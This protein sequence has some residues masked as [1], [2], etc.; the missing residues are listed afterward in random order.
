MSHA[1][2]SEI[3]TDDVLQVDQLFKQLSEEAIDLRIVEKFFSEIEHRMLQL[4][5]SMFDI[6]PIKNTLQQLKAFTSETP[7][8]EVWQ[9]ESNI[10]Q[11]FQNWLNLLEK[12]DQKIETYHFR[13]FCDTSKESLDTVVF[14]ALARFYRNL[15]HSPSNQSKF[16]LVITRLFTK[17]RSKTF[18][19]MSLERTNLTDHLAHLFNRWDNKT[20]DFNQVSDETMVA[21]S[22]IDEFICETQSLTSFEDLVKNNLFDRFRFFKRDL[23]EQ[24]FEPVIVAAAIECNLA[25][26]NVFNKLLGNANE[27][28]STKLTSAFDFAEAF[29]DTSPNAQVHTSEL[30]HEVKLHETSDGT[31]ENEELLHIWELLE[32]VGAENNLPPLAIGEVETADSKTSNKSLPPQDRIAPLLATLSTPQPDLKLLRDYTQKS[33]SLS[34]LD[35]KDFLHSSEKNTDEICRDALRLILW[36]EEIRENELTNPKSLPL[37]IRDEVKTILRRSQNLAEQ[38]GLLIENADQATQNRLLIVANKLLETSLKLERAIVRFSNRNLGRTKTPEKESPVTRP[39]PIFVLNPPKTAKPPVN[40]W[41]IAATILV[42]LLSGGIFFFSDQMNSAIPP[43]KNVEQIDV[44]K[45]S[46]GE[47]LQ[48]AYRKENVLFVTAKDSWSQLSKAEQGETLKN[49]LGYPSQPR[50]ET[51]IITDG[52]GAPL[53]DISA[54]GLNIGENPQIAEIQGNK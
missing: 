24:F 16:D 47:H 50:L 6:G 19:Q 29:H 11:E 43:P 14:S 26:G 46:K 42:F 49:L 2:N 35:L 7:L 12:R 54:D 20:K 28:L 13:R 38:L 5:A 53:G 45:L 30:L 4:S 40:R 31:S 33:N 41:L 9:A 36:S 17:E 25:V 15:P 52:K 22:K 32:M 44:T 18:R 21:L 3:E 37:T 1:I 23:E 51:I 39:K 10:K 27:N 34:S 48:V 8:A